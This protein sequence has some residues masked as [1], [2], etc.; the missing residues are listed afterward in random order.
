MTITRKRAR[1]GIIVHDVLT[2]DLQGD[3]ATVAAEL[4]RVDPGAM[5]M[6]T[7]YMEAADRAMAQCERW[8]PRWKAARAMRIHAREAARYLREGDAELSTWNALQAAHHAW[9]GDVKMVEP[10]IVTGAK[11]RKGGDKGRASRKAGLNHDHEQWRATAA[12]MREK[13]PK[14]SNRDIATAI[15][16]DHWHTIRRVIAKPKVI[17]K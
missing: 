10:A 5:G 13:N 15:D 17:A 2:T 14:L 9:V 11:S 8:S 4:D 12:A 7:G 16:P 1:D 6:L 3:A